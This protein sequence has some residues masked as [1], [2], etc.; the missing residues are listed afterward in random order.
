ML[1]FLNNFY[2]ILNYQL[3]NNTNKEKKCFYLIEA[4]L[5]GFN[6]IFIYVLYTYFSILQT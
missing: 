5:S 1:P 6:N 3:I 2:Y 4:D